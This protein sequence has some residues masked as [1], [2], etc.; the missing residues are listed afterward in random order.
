MLKQEADGPRAAS[1]ADM[2]RDRCRR[3]AGR[4]A[5]VAF[6]TSLT[7]RRLLL[8]AEAF[9]RS[10][11]STGLREG[12]RVAVL[13]PN[14]LAF[15]VVAFGVL[16]AGG[17]LAPLNPL[18][19]AR[20]VEEA[21]D[22]LDPKVI[23]ASPLLSR[24]LPVRPAVPV[25]GASL[26]DCHGWKAP[27]IRHNAR[28]PKAPAEWTPLARILSDR[29]IADIAG[30]SGSALAMLQG[31]GGSTGT[32]KYGRLIDDNLLAAAH[33]LLAW[34]EGYVPPEDPRHGLTN[35]ATL[36]LYH[37]FGFVTCAMVS[38]MV[39]AS[40]TY[41]GSYPAAAKKLAHS[42]GVIA[43]MASRIARQRSSTV[44]AA[45]LRSSA[46]SLE[47]AFSIGLKSGL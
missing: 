10:L 45:A 13:L 3:H 5:Y 18:Y 24:L 33:A 4:S 40:S 47:K 25:I 38:L 43:S 44:R 46:L 23:V 7:Y 9:A 2:I 17:V 21:L 19:T 26:G 34:C 30:R 42:F 28:E 12:D 15:P 41:S 20:E 29:T 36:P 8:D 22:R 14:S 37:A 35:M 27:I 16:L 1:V 6:G 39:G 31:T 32:P 11:R